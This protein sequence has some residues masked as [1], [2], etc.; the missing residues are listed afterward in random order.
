[1]TATSSR[2]ITVILALLLGGPQASAQSARTSTNVSSTITATNVFQSV[3]A[4]T[5]NRMDCV[6]QNNGA[7]SQWVFFGPIASA[8][9]GGAILLTPG[10]AV[11]CAHAGIVVEDQVSITGTIADTFMASW[12]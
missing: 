8:S 12:Q 4:A 5:V 3:I 10:Q 7:N 1:M 6:V 11:N 2:L 9:K